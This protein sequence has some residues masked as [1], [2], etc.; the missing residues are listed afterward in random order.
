LI[1]WSGSGCEGQ[2]LD[3]GAQAALVASGL[4][5]VEDALVGN[6]VHHSLHLAKQLGRF[7][8]VASGN[9]LLDVLDGGAVFGT[10]RRVRSVEFDVLTGAFAT[11]GQAGVLFLRLSRCH[12]EY[13][14][15][16]EDDVSEPGILAEP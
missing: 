1:L 12:F 11:R 10:Q 13:P 8:F 14:L 2:G 7:G 6:G 4:V 16:S 9:S 3:L 15:M 5:L